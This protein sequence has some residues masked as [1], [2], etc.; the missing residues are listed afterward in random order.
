MDGKRAFPL[1]SIVIENTLYKRLNDTKCS[2]CETYCQARED[3]FRPY[4]RLR[5]REEKGSF[6][7]AMTIFQ[8]M[9]RISSIHQKT[10]VSSLLLPSVY[11][12]SSFFALSIIQVRQLSKKSEL[13]VPKMVITT[14]LMRFERALHHYQPSNN[15]KG[16]SI[17]SATVSRKRAPRAPSITR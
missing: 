10:V 5:A 17:N 13:D 9:Y 16:S 8:R 6:T 4:T 3:F 14:S 1:Y 2:I 12:S 7:P 15:P 11:S